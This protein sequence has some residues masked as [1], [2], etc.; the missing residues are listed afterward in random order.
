MKE[1]EVYSALIPALQK[2]SLIYKQIVV[3]SEKIATSLSSQLPVQQVIPLLKKKN[4]MLDSV[5]QLNKEVLVYKKAWQ[6]NKNKWSENKNKLKII[7]LLAELS[8]DIAKVVAL[9]KK[10]TTMATPTT[11]ASNKYSAQK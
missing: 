9:E 4:T 11:N 1:E 6:D 5:V 7:Q 3:V 10:N 8:V 2:Q